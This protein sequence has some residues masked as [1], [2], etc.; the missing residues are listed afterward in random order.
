M[1]EHFKEAVC[2]DAGRVYDS[3]CDRDCLEDLRL[4]FNPTD[5]EIVNAGVGARARTAT[6]LTTVVN[7]EPI[8]F[9]RGYYSVD[10]TFY[11]LV[12]VDVY[13]AD[14]STPTTVNGIGT[15]N[16]RVI[17]FGSEGSAKIFSSNTPLTDFDTTLPV[18]SNT[19]TAVVQSVDP[20]I[21]SELIAPCTGT[22]CTQTVTFPAAVLAVIGGT[23]AP[24]DTV[25]TRIAVT[26]GLF[27]VVQ[28]V[29]NV[30]MLMPVYDFCVPSKECVTT[31]DNPCDV[32]QRLQFPMNEFFPQADQCDALNGGCGNCDRDND[33]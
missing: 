24:A 9:N 17:L 20:V 18:A 3:C 15:F 12:T 31:T 19:P 21:L 6:L 1:A 10:M 28:L 30:Q 22:E 32:F 13:A 33:Q 5:Q 25:T 23:L 14:T 4:F 7:V 11:F 27:S 16:K 29:R 2:V 26:L 8:T